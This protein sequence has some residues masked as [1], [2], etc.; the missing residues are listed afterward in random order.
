[1][2]KKSKAKKSATKKSTTKKINKCPIDFYLV[3]SSFEKG[4]HKY[5]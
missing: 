4:E 1:M 2:V 5:E 3:E